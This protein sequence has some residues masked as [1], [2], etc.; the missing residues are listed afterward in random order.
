MCSQVI[1][2]LMVARKRGN[3]VNISSVM[4]LGAHPMRSPYAAAKAGVNAL[5]QTLS[6]ELAPHGIRV[7]AIAPGF[8]EVARFFTQFKN[9]A[10]EV[11]PARLA[12]VPLGIMGETDDVACLATF[13]ASDAA[14][15]IT[16]QVIRVDGGLTTTVFFKTEDPMGGWW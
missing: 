11:R 1:G 15:Y 10:T 5:T 7:N 4:S 2:R 3:I 9:Y 16:G 12:K 14:R 8:I 6:V 13:L